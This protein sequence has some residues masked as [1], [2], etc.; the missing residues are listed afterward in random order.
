MNQGMTLNC[1]PT[2]PEEAVLSSEA[3]PKAQSG[4]QD[5][6]PDLTTNL[7]C[8]PLGRILFQQAVPSKRKAKFTDYLLCVTCEVGVFKHH[9]FYLQSKQ[10]ISLR[11]MT[12]KICYTYLNNI[13][14]NYHKTDSH[15]NVGKE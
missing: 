5:A 13:L 4:Y 12:V 11:N 3:M 2:L 6:I 8:K 1:T 7:N 15:G 14:I 9:Y 10:R